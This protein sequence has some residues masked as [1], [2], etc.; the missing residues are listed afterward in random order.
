MRQEARQS[1]R[2][3]RKFPDPVFQSS[4]RL[5]DVRFPF[6]FF[7][8]AP[9]FLAQL[10]RAAIVFLIQLSFSSRAQ[11]SDAIFSEPHPFSVCVV[12]VFLF[13]L[14]V[15]NRACRCGKRHV[16]HVTALACPR[17]TGRVSVLPCPWGNARVWVPPCP[18][19]NRV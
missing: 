6:Q 13:V 19:G 8:A 12:V 17:G 9:S 11:L 14:A 7:R 4:A 10:L 15:P 5:R 1:R 18:W 3:F 16:G 2:S